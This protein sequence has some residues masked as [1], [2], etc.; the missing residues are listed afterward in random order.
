MTK[1]S[2]AQRHAH[3]NASRPVCQVHLFTVSLQ[4]PPQGARHDLAHT[5]EIM[6]SL[7]SR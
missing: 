4:L 7:T 3:Q 2:S 5:L 6:R 1:L